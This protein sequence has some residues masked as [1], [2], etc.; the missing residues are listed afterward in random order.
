MLVPVWSQINLPTDFQWLSLYHCFLH[1]CLDFMSI[2]KLFFFF[3]LFGLCRLD[4]TL[5]V[6]FF[7]TKRYVVCLVV[8]IPHPASNVNSFWFQTSKM[9]MVLNLFFSLAVEKQTTNSMSCTV[10]KPSLKRSYLGK[11][12]VCVKCPYR[13]TLGS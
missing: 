1:C 8:I 4:A 2:I 9:T 6:L 10:S 11:G 3:I 7:H 5:A 12:G 13:L